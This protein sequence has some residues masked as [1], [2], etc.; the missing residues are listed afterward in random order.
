MVQNRLTADALVAPMLVQ[1]L[2]FRRAAECCRC[3][4]QLASKIVLEEHLGHFTD[5]ELLRCSKNI[6][7]GL[8]DGTDFN[9]L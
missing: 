1:L 4:A 7:S 3:T 8:E 2:R 6:T 5:F 9:S